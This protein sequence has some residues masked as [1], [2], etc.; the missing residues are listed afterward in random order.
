MYSYEEL[1]HEDWKH[2]NI[3]NNTN[4]NYSYKEYNIKIGT[5][6]YYLR[7]EIS[8]NKIKFIAKEFNT[9]LDYNYKINLN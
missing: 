7:I 6:I 4:D 1:Y 8:K 9:P 3:K 5:I 2:K